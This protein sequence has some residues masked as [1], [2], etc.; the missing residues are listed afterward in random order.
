MWQAALTFYRLSG[1]RLGE[2]Y[3]LNNLG[4]LYAQQEHWA[5][6]TAMYER[7]LSIKREIGDRAGESENL[8]G[9]GE[10]LL[11]QGRWQ[12]ASQLF[13]QAL[14]LRQEIS[15]RYGEAR[16]LSSLGQVYRHQGCTS[17]AL[18]A[19]AASL[20]IFRQLGS[21]DE[22]DEIVR[23]LERVDPGADNKREFAVGSGASELPPT[24]IL[25]SNCQV[26]APQLQ[27]EPA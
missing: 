13:A 11:R 4:D 23:E 8:Q 27:M 14:R 18:E 17:A 5:Q 26:S 6:A 24:K 12:E 16:T 9:I 7:S 20:S 15:D 1:D 2:S 21:H 3:V 22:T 19:F 25:C 10:L